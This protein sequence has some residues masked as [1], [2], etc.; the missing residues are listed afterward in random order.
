MLQL[1]TMTAYLIINYSVTDG[2]AYKE[3]QGGA[4]P[5]LRIGSECKILVLDP[6]SERIE[7]D[8][9]G[10]QTV[11]LEFESRDKAKE[12]YNS[13][14]YQAVLPIRLGATTDHFAVLVDGFTM[15]GS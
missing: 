3:Y 2:D 5:A 15:P 10:H 4:A 12:L 11:V 1:S 14:E 6:A 13:G 8:G 7:G 9:A